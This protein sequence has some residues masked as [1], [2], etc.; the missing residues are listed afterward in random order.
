[1][2][3]TVFKNTAYYSGSVVTD[4]SGKATVSFALPDNI[5]NYRVI[6]VANTLRSYFGTTELTIP[7][8]KKVLIEDRT[9]TIVHANDILSLG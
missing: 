3:R 8:R 1:M 4:S 9:P 7:V 5:T 6:V 2:T